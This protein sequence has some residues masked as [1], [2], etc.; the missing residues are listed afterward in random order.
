M[1]QPWRRR[2]GGSIVRRLHGSDATPGLG[3]VVAAL[4]LGASAVMSFRPKTRRF[5][6]DMI[7]TVVAGSKL[8]KPA[9]PQK[10]PPVLNLM[11]SH[12]VSLGFNKA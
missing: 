8:D 2:G 10:A 1:T 12:G 6:T 5:H 7:P 3:P 9:K 4:S 11:L